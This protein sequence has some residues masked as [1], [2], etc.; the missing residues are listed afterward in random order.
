[1]L[2]LDWEGWVSSHEEDGEGET[3]TDGLTD[4]SV[5]LKIELFEQCDCGW[6]PETAVSVALTVPT[7]ELGIQRR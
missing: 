4:L 5:G 3:T 1:M 6:R 7:G 2:R